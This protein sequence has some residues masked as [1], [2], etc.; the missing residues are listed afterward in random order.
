MVR[1]PLNRAELFTE[2]VIEITAAGIRGLLHGLDVEIKLL[3]EFAALLD[4]Y[5]SPEDYQK[6]QGEIALSPEGAAILGQLMKLPSGS[7][8]EAIQAATKKMNDD[9]AALQLKKCG[10][11]VLETWP[12]EK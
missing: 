4:T 6:C 8:A 5:K 2:D 10:Q 7:T 1:V 9:F 12:V 3:N 11:N